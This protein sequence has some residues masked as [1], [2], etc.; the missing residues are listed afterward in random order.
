M[1]ASVGFVPLLFPRFCLETL[2]GLVIARAPLP[3]AITGLPTPSLVCNSLAFRLRFCA[4]RGCGCGWGS[5]R[6][7]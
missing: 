7:G 6:S 5:E 3:P 1:V 2:G 4:G